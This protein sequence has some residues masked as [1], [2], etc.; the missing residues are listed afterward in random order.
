MDA[1]LGLSADK[2]LRAAAE[3]YG[4]DSIPAAIILTHGHF[5]HIGA[6]RELAKLW[7]VPVY[8]HSLEAPY[9]TGISAYPPPNPLAGGGMSAMSPIYP[10]GPIDLGRRLT[11]LPARGYLPAL[12][13]W[14]WIH[15]PGHTPGHISL[16][17]ATD[18]VLIAGDAFVTTRQ[19]SLAGALLKPEVVNGPP[20]YFTPNWN[21]AWKSVTFLSQ[22]PISVA[23]TGHGK[24]MYGEQLW[25][26]LQYLVNNFWEEAVPR[27]G[28]YVDGTEDTHMAEP[29]QPLNQSSNLLPTLIF[30]AAAL[31]TLGIIKAIKH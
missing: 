11:Q 20:A 2:I 10:R 1:G 31:S 27:H 19:E 7:D 8:C 6:V 5:D 21:D 16:Y 18:G 15:T 25:Q 28:R 30:A 12:Q 13:D 26:G 4:P 29:V 9:L 17:R 3:L 22:I 14:E 23:A 24:P